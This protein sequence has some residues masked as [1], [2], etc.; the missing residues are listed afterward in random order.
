[1]NAIDDFTALLGTGEVVSQ[2]LRSIREEPAY[3][4]RDIY[5]DYQRTGWTGPDHYL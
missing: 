3:L 4:L 5:R 1:M 2:M